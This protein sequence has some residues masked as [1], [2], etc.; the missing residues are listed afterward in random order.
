MNNRMGVICFFSCISLLLYSAPSS[1]RSETIQN[2]ET[3]YVDSK[4]VL[5]I[6][7]NGLRLP[8]DRN[9]ALRLIEQ[10]RSSL[11]KNIYLSVLVDSSHQLGNYLAE[12]KIALSDIN[13][14]I[15][16]GTSTVPVFSSTMDEVI[17]YHQTPFQQIANLFVKHN[18][19]YTP[20][21]FPL[22]TATKKYTGILID[23]RGQ[24]P[25][26]GEYTSEKLKP[27][28]FP[29]IWDQNMNLIYEK[30]IVQ[31]DIARKQSIVL[32]TS[33]LD[34]TMYRDRI[35]TEP[36]RI[37]AR[38]VFGDHKTDPII[39]NAD[40][41]KILVK[42]E[43][44]QLLK[45]GKIVIVCDKDTLQVS[46]A[47]PLPDE[48]FYF[49]YH[50]IT[51]LILQELPDTV[52]VKAPNNVITLTMYDVRFIADS[53]EIVPN[54]KNSLDVI[55]AALKRVGPKAHFLIEGHTADLNRPEA[56]QLLSLQRAQKIA[57]ELSK[58]GIAPE[59]MTTAGYGATR[60]LVPSN[61]SENRAKNRR[62]EITI[63]TE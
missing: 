2:W 7:K 62:V 23:A 45:E 49:A 29:K 44:L 41:E 20:S 11:L 47:F 46:P 18:A 8:T 60:P 22:G 6:H 34:E 37:I 30:N 38:G 31:P 35:G 48:H 16:Q 50:D 5:D 3:R 28:L 40:A 10:N 33:T 12:E 58:R 39:S 63:L 25:I 54:E 61:T 27:C 36:L 14:I 59:R 17:V 1:M 52:V 24:L 26:H 53:P 13:A 4:I 42:Q 43:N 9:A 55:A 56:E 21:L 15:N 32:Y 57:E 51:N 19:P